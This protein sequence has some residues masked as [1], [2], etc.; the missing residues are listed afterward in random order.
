MAA[1]TVRPKVFFDIKIGGKDAGR[2]VMEL[3]KDSCPRTVENFRCL[4]TGEKGIGGYTRKKLHYKNTIFHRVIKGFMAQG[5]DFVK[6]DGTGGESI[7]GTTFRDENFIHRHFG[8]GILSMAN[9]GPH[10]NG[11]QFFIT[12]RSTPHLNDK[13]VV[14]GRV[15]EGMETLRRIEEVRTGASDRPNVEVRIVDCGELKAAPK[16]PKIAND[17]EIDLLVSDD[18]EGE[19]NDTDNKASKD[20]EDEEK[21]PEKTEAEILAEQTKGMSARQKKLFELRQ[22]MNAGRKAN[23]REAKE[24]KLR[25]QKGTKTEKSKNYDRW[26]EYEAKKKELEAAGLDPSDYRFLNDTAM[27]HEKAEKRRLEKEKNK[28]PFGWNVFNQDSLYRAY[29]KRLVNVPKG[30]HNGGEIRTESSLKWGTDRPPEHMIDH[31]VAELEET[32]NRRKKFSR[33]RQHYAS[34]DIDYINDRNRV[35]NKKIKRAYDPYTI[36]IRQ[37]LERGTAL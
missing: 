23:R 31:M 36:E 9:C 18:E 5:G 30:E 6:A 10:S 19:E 4:C 16:A 24:E 20:K 17:E 25:F 3:F 2:M 12:F 21:V 34:N 22:K 13:H 14:F 35:F 8:P 37:N 15:V 32:H 1:A 26:K 7:Y 11:S 29:E 27:G 28:A 33:R